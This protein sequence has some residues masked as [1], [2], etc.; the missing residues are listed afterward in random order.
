MILEHCQRA[1]CKQHIDALKADAER[2]RW[3]TTVGG[4]IGMRLDEVQREW[5]GCDGVDG[6]NEA[7]ARC[8][9]RRH[10][11]ESK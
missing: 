2:Y 6:F 11:K 8:I 1:E 4:G 3:L 10:K 7:M 9:E 5:N